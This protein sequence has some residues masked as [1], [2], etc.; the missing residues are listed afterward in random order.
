[1]GNRCGKNM[2]KKKFITYRTFQILGRGTAFKQDSEW[3]HKVSRIKPK[4][5]GGN[6]LD[7]FKCP[8][9]LI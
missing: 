5:I 9:V 1:M 6:K 4:N 2:K 7:N 3:G 8:F